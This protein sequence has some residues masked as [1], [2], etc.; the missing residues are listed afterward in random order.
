MQASAA[1]SYLLAAGKALTGLSGRPA[2]AGLARQ[3]MDMG[4][5]SHPEGQHSTSLW[6]HKASKAVHTMQPATIGKSW[7]EGYNDSVL[8]VKTVT[9]SSG[10]W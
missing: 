2:G 4:R 5:L 8:L 6:A 3:K 7:S 10:C 9:V 1:W